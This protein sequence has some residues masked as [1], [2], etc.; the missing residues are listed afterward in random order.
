M[1][2]MQLV[3]CKVR[4]PDDP[5][6]QII[7]ALKRT[8]ARGTNGNGLAVVAQQLGDGLA[9]HTDILRVHLMPL[10]LLALHRLERAGSHM[11]S[12]LLALNTMGIE[13][14]QY[15][16]RKVKTGR[17]S[18]HTTLNLRVNGLVGGLIAVLCLTVEI[19]R[20]GQ[21]THRIDDGGKGWK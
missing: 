14:G 19:G 6:T 16:G 3:F 2:Y 20:D 10:H 13:V 17:G 7:E 5:D 4:M 12:Q 9:A 21:F 15:L 11:K 8:H 18:S 1:G